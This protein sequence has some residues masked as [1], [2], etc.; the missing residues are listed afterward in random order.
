MEYS[1]HFIFELIKI[2]IL[3][4]VYSTI[5]YFIYKNIPKSKKP[6]WYEKLLISK[7]T[8][9]LY[10]SIF[11]LFYMFTPYGNHGLGDS[12]RIPIS[13]T[14]EISNI[15]WTVYGKLNDVKSNEKNDI[16]LTQ[17]KVEKD[18][19]CGNLSSDF[20][21]YKNSYFIYDIDSEK[22]QEF[23]TESDYNNFT[24]NKN[25]PKSH[26]LKSFKENYDDYWS[27]WRLFLLP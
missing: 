4:F 13:L 26:E 6:E 9:W 14:K 1:G 5:L 25:L 22:L 16:Y 11:L 24:K 27:G 3:G 7:K 23:K 8:L 18:I 17:F 19:L 20:Y 10:I 15:N 21:D 12:A 2:T